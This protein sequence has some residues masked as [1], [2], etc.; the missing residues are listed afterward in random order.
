MLEMSHKETPEDTLEAS[1]MGGKPQH[2][3]AHG[4]ARNGAHTQTAA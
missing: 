2:G 4:D 1:K 3:T